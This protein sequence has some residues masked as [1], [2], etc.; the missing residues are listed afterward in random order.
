MPPNP[1]R[2]VNCELLLHP[3][4]CET[5]EAQRGED[6]LQFH[7][8]EPRK[9]PSCVGFARDAQLSEGS[10]VHRHQV[11]DGEQQ[12]GP[13]QEAA[14]HPNAANPTA[15]I[16]NKIKIAHTLQ[17]QQGPTPTSVDRINQG[18]PSTT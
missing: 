3:R 1:A 11:H 5:D 6:A 4:A 14:Q 12:F 18:A 15:S 9:T 17:E 8:E 13:L 16:I 10:A 7:Y 2:W